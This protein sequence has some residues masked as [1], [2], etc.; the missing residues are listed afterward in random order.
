M[1]IVKK[2]GQISA[3]YCIY[4][5]VYWIVKLFILIKMKLLV[6]IFILKLYAQVDIF[7]RIQEK[8]RQEI[9]KIVRKVDQISAK[10]RIYFMVYWINELFI[11]IKIKLLVILFILKEKKFNFRVSKSKWYFLFFD[12]ALANRSL[13]F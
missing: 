8:Y 13:T 11:L 4:F 7:K 10:Y 6:I 2:I 5:M 1:K 12:F 3:K 9:M